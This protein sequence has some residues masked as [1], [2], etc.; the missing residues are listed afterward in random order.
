M[1][2]RP[3]VTQTAKKLLPAGR[4][5]LQPYL[6]GSQPDEELALGYTQ[7]RKPLSPRCG[8]SKRERERGG[9][10]ILLKKD[11]SMGETKFSFAFSK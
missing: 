3:H 5:K 9:E 6:I 4:I 10:W 7:P 2:Q 8:E 11:F 1:G